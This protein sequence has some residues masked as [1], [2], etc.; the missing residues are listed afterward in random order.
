MSRVHPCLIY[1]WFDISCAFPVLHQCIYTHTISVERSLLTCV[2]D[3]VWQSLSQSLVVRWGWKSIR[4][5]SRASSRS[6]CSPL[7]QLQHNTK[8]TVCECVSVCVTQSTMK[9]LLLSFS[10]SCT[11]P[12]RSHI[13][14]S[15][16]SFVCKR[17][18]AGLLQ[19]ERSQTLYF[20]LS[21]FRKERQ[22][23][24]SSC[25]VSQCFH[26]V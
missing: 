14:W 19:L 9:P 6:D 20:F 10:P 11:A 18:E 26:T 16:F 21:M 7:A 8:H 3:A 17:K 15:N 2:A 5:G 25:W 23:D 12:I 13:F 4:K 1:K 24:E 22:R